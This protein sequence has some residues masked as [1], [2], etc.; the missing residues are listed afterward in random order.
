MSARS[1]VARAKARAVEA[2]IAQTAGQ[3]LVL[4]RGCYGRLAANGISRREVDRAL[5]DLEGRGRILV[6]HCGAGP[7]VA[8]L[9]G[10]GR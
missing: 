4:D 9:V 6:F 1:P 5:A 10:G 8:R 7:I 3:R 2:A